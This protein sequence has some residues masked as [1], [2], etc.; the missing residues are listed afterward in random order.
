MGEVCILPLKAP[1]KVL[2]NRTKSPE[3]KKRAFLYGEILVYYELRT[4]GAA[5]TAQREGAVCGIVEP[6]SR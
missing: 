5:K 3:K 6:T 1:E 2:K 4:M